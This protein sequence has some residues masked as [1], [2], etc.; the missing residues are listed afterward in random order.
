MKYQYSY[1]FRTRDVIIRP[2]LEHFKKLRSIVFP[3]FFLYVHLD[4]PAVYLDVNA[5]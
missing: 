5:R 4:L 3:S 1:V 2:A